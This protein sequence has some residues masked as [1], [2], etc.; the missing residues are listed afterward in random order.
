MSV[1][2]TLAF[3]T[4]VNAP[5]VTHMPVTLMMQG[6][7]RANVIEL[8][9]M[10][11][12][13]PL[14]LDGYSAVLYLGRKD[15]VRVRCPGTVAG[16]VA[17]VTLQ[18]ECYSV[19]GPYAAM[20]KLT[21]SEEKRTVLRLAGYVESDGEG[22]IIDPS[23][24][25]PSYED[26]ARIMKELEEALRQAENA[27]SGANAAAQNANTA[28]GSANAAADAANT[29]ASNANEAASALNGLTA[30]A[31]T[32][33]SD[34]PATGEAKLVDGAWKIELGVPQGIQGVQGVRGITAY[35]GS[36]ITGTSTTP[37]AYATGIASAL[38]SDLYLYTGSD[39]ANIGNVYTC[40]Q[41]GDASTALW[42]YVTNWRGAPGTGNVS[43]V[44]GVQP[45]QEGNVDLPGQI[46][47]CAAAAL[48]DMT[49]E[50]QAEL[51]TQG[52]RA[53]QA[54]NNDTVVTLALA[55]DGALSWQGCNEDTANLLDNPNFAIAQAGYG[56]AHG[57][58]KY[59]ADRWM[60][61]NTASAQYA[62]GMV[63]VT[64][65][66]TGN[67]AVVQAMDSGEGGEFTVNADIT[68]PSGG[69]WQIV[70]FNLE[71][72]SPVVISS[73]NGDE[74]KT[75]ILNVTV[76]PNVKIWVGLYPTVG[77]PNGMGIV[78]NARLL[79]GSYTPKTLP[80]WETT[81]YADSYLECSRYFNI[82]NLYTCTTNSNNSFSIHIPFRIPMRVIP[83]TSVFST[84]TGAE[85]YADVLDG[86]EWKQI[87]VYSEPY[88]NGV[89]VFGTSNGTNQL[90]KFK[91]SSSADL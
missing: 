4:D 36:A 16:N 88:Q 39:N 49:Q 3:R 56:G 65:D 71:S 89:R 31:T 63:N 48:E 2:M 52:Y 91:I 20:M 15:G 19:P 81:K 72:E 32:L 40:T 27:T 90:V 73:S 12:D 18:A 8:T 50:Q 22:P 57:T 38:A 64:D 11:G 37:T 74:T 14:N 60:G 24:T 80:P 13:T 5:L 82:E 44:N 26:L 9:M 1:A 10:D 70:M 6:D 17:K 83:T 46:Y 34:Q 51:Y 76:P 75:P 23:G 55:A 78:G 35:Q 68:P 7:D 79:R 43:T 86:S 53:V 29:A 84:I 42:A 47:P 59:V 28:A 41:G 62:D 30:S 87:V 45:D 33:A 67:C 85:G 69:K 54:T 66:G 21:G 61:L 77:T 58:Q 25:I